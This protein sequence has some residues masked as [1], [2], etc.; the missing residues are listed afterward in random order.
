[1][2]VECSG[3]RLAFLS[4]FAFTP[5]H[6]PSTPNQAVFTTTIT[7]SALEPVTREKA[8]ARVEGEEGGREETKN[9][10]PPDPPTC[11]SSASFSFFF[12]SPNPRPGRGRRARQALLVV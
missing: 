7:G 10:L 3:R 11:L 8:L 12:F 1:M 2:L 4:A 5:T 9:G 6:I